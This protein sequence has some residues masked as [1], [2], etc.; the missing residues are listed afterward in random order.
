VHRAAIAGVLGA[1]LDVFS[2]GATS[3]SCFQSSFF[4]SSS[5]FRPY[6][7]F[8]SGYLINLFSGTAALA[9]P[10]QV[11][12]HPRGGRHVGGFV[13]G[14]ILCRLVCAPAPAIATRRISALEWAWEPRT[15]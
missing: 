9:G 13:S 1:Y 12:W 6:F 11:G 14:V 4:P 15:R 10:Q 2:D 5:R 7:I 3:L 8:S